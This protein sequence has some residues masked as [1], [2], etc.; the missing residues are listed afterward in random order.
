MRRNIKKDG[1]LT[2]SERRKTEKGS[3]MG[4]LVRRETGMLRPRP[5]P[6]RDVA[7]KALGGSLELGKI[8]DG[9][10]QERPS[11]AFGTFSPFHGEKEK[12]VLRANGSGL[13]QSL[14]FSAGL[15]SIV[16][17]SLTTT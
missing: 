1:T 13:P 3:T 17:S 4:V 9:L 5:H 7:E 10:K 16:P 6:G 8:K 11:S 2:V 15:S 12:R 14:N